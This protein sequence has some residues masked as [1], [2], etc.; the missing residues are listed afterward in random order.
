MKK[1]L[2][3]WGMVF[4]MIIV[5]IVWAF[6]FVFILLAEFFKGLVDKMLEVMHEKEKKIVEKTKEKKV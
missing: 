1:F 4:L 2:N 3:E 5:V 6:A